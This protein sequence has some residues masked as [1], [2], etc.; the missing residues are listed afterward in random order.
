MAIITLNDLYDK[1]KKVA[2]WVTGSDA[3][4]APAVKLTGS[5]PAGDNALGQVK[6][7]VWAGGTNFQNPIMGTSDSQSS[8]YIPSAGTTAFNGTTWDRWRNNQQGTLLASATRT[9]NTTTPNQTNHNARGVLVSLI[10]TA[11]SGTGGLQIQVYG[12]SQNGGVLGYSAPLPSSAIT[13]TGRYVYTL[14]PSASLSIGGNMVAAVN[15]PLVRTW[16]VT[17]SHLDGTNYTYYVDFALI[18]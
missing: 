17:I 5:I 8:L 14:Y 4:S 1:W 11:A 16:Y 13:T 2:D 3:V 10:V 6:E 12:L 7:L 15:Q 18:Q 9:A